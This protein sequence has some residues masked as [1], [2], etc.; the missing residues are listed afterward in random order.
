[1]ATVKGYSRAQIGLHWI[2]A[3]LILVQ[4]VFEDSIGEAWEIIE[5]GGAATYGSGALLHIGVG[6]TVLLLALWR[7]SLRSARGVP[8]PPE[9]EPPLLRTA[10]HLGHLALYALMILMPVS[11][12]VAWFGGVEA[13]AEVHQLMKPA[14]I[15]LVVIH[16]A[17]TIWHQ[18][19]LKDNLM[20]RMKRPLD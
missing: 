16:V 7:L 18:F 6:I 1:M 4:I 10:A 15:V 13:A 8:P 5:D 14:L 9:T 20:A 11:G 12:L 19:W 2:V 3:I 17:A